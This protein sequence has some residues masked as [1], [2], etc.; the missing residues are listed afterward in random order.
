MPSIINVEVV[1][2]GLAATGNIIQVNCDDNGVP[3][4]SN[5]KKWKYIFSNPEKYKEAYKIL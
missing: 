3:N 1:A 2:K 5:A 4:G